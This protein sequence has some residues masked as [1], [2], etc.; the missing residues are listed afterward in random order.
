MEIVDLGTKIIS[1]FSRLNK[2]EQDLTI[3]LLKGESNINFFR[4][5]N[6]LEK[7]EEIFSLAKYVSE[8]NESYEVV[9]K[10]I[11]LYEDE[12][13]NEKNLSFSDFFYKIRYEL[14][15]Q[16]KNVLKEKKEG[17]D[18]NLL[19]RS[20]LFALTSDEDFYSDEILDNAKLMTLINKSKNLGY[21]RLLIDNLVEDNYKDLVKLNAE[22]KNTLDSLFNDKKI[23]LD[24]KISLERFLES[25][26]DILRIQSA[27]KGIAIGVPIS[28]LELEGN[29]KSAEFSKEA[30]V[31][32]VISDKRVEQ[33]LGTDLKN[34]DFVH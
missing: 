13:K 9:K 14:Q 27:E 18:R 31:C 28:S 23:N 32:A 8:Q 22:T 26:E 15:S 33:V 21:A 25:G 34:W 12:T 30:L 1:D 19:L 2:K 7:R 4:E 20:I 11:T 17:E 5:I 24:Q 29:I 3:R 16:I 6:Y 10:L